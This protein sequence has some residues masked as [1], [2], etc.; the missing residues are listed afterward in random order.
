MAYQMI[1]SPSSSPMPTSLRGTTQAKLNLSLTVTGKRADGYHELHSIV[2]FC[3]VG[4]AIEVYEADKM[5]LTVSGEHSDLLSTPDNLML[6]AAQLLKDYTGIKKNAHLTLDKHLPIASG[7]GGG[8]GDAALT[9]QLLN[10]LWQCHLP[11]K[12]LSQ[13][14]LKL[15]AD[16]PVCLHNQA[17]IM[18]GIGEDITPLAPLP[19]LYALLV[20]P[21]KSIETR[22]IFS[23]ITPKDYQQEPEV[24]TAITQDSLRFMHNILQQ[25]TSIAC[26]EIPSIISALQNTNDPICTRMSGSGATCFA[27][28]TTQEDVKKA[29]KTIKTTFPN[30]WV[31]SGLLT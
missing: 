6:R 21:L 27:L 16:V 4:D 10:Q 9:L 22:D 31:T 20:N 25:P 28:Y 15:G 24:I 30:Y 1:A 7:I 11:L 14:G 2:A 8:S 19:S 29:Q 17:C 23:K 3:D 13:L 12:V 5:Q 26:P 18:K